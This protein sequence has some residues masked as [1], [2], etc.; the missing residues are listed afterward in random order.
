[1]QIHETPIRFDRIP[2]GEYLQAFEEA[3][4]V[5]RAEVQAI[6]SNPEAP[7]FENTIEALEY[8]AT[9]TT[10]KTC[11]STCWRPIPTR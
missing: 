6:T 3:V 2:R 10:W 1:M 8:A 11:F 7:T 4:A 5:A 9:W